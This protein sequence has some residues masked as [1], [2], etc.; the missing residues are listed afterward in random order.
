MKQVHSAEELVGA[1]LN[2]G[3]QLVVLNYFSLG[4][5]ACRSVHPKVCWSNFLSSVPIIIIISS[6]KFKI[7]FPLPLDGLDTYFVFWS[8]NWNSLLYVI[9][10]FFWDLNKSYLSWNVFIFPLL[11]TSHPF[12]DKNPCFPYYFCHVC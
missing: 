8:Y 3:D 4:C 11:D 6:Y 9:N 1:L 5:G 12:G 7:C 2:A 10:H